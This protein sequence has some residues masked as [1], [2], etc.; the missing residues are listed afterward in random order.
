M[1]FIRC[2][3]IVDFSE[4]FIDAVSFVCFIYHKI[5]T[6]LTSG[7]LLNFN[8]K[9]TFRFSNIDPVTDAIKFVKLL[10]WFNTNLFYIKTYIRK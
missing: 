1:Y 3:K 10:Q 4:N 8:L 9:K 7:M 2:S 6:H 5:Q